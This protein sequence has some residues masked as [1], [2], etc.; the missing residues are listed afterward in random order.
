MKKCFY[1]AASA[2]AV[3]LSLST[4]ASDITWQK[5]TPANI[6]AA[7][8]SHGEHVTYST[9]TP[10]ANGTASVGSESKVARGD[11]VHPLQ[12]T[13]SGNAGTATKLKTARTITVDGVV[14]GSTSFDGSQNVTITTVANDIT[15][16]TK[17]LTVTTDWMDTGIA[18]SNLSTGTYAVQ[19]YVDSEGQG[20][21]WDE[22][23]SGI[24]SWY[25][26]GT[27][28]GEADEIFLHK[29]GH[30]TN[31]EG[32]FLRTIRQNS[33]DNKVL[34]LQIAASKAFTAEV[35]LQ[36]KFKKLI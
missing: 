4:C 30:A 2:C 28:S 19:L 1:F 21:Q 26:G 23:Y 6:G 9:T 14:S 32:I 8:S 3:L 7:A 29:A 12:T 27:N 10:K 20:G 34:K 15:T 22:Y 25:S 16:I 17:S 35:S 33:G 36:F 13:V 5:I 18:G 11:H 31:S 24:M